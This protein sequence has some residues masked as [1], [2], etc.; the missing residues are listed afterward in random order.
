MVGLVV[1][2]A[3]I[4]LWRI[5]INRD[6]LKHEIQENA[7]QIYIRA[8]HVLPTLL[9]RYFLHK[10]ERT[11]D[12]SLSTYDNYWNTFW[13]TKDI[14]RTDLPFTKFDKPI[15]ELTPFESR[16][17][18]I[19]SILAEKIQRTNV[20]SVLEVG[21]GTGL[22]LLLLAPVFPHVTFTGL[23]PSESGV[24]ISNKLVK[25]P[26]PE[27]EE[28]HKTGEIRNIEIIRGFILDIEAV[29]RLTNYKFD[30]VY[31]SAV[32]EQL[33]NYVDIAFENIFK[34]TSKYF[35]FFEEW[36]EANHLIQNYLTLIRSDY[37][38]LSWNYLHRYEGIEILERSIP[39]IQ[40][41]WLKYGVVFGK[42][43]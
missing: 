19:V 33:H 4:H 5:E 38:R 26:P 27:F 36:L 11:Q 35:L 1:I 7:R 29:E 8:F 21:S 2:Q 41:S 25:A 39:S 22:N 3:N 6:N 17:A 37:F 30:L 20:S 40:P 42:K 32:L 23:E 18:G 9:A 10:G 28:A 13:E 15:G 34:L 43:S 24:K 31:T 12:L 14:F 16:K